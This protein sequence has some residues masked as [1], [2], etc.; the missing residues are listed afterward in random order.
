MY[1]RSL[2]ILIFLTFLFSFQS[3]SKEE[4][5][6]SIHDIKP[7]AY[8]ENGVFKGPMI[9]IVD[10]LLKDL[11]IKGQYQ[12]IPWIRT[13]ESARNGFQ[14]LIVRHSMNED[15]KK[16]LKPILIGFVNREV[17]Y[18]KKRNSSVKVKKFEDL[19]SYRIGVKNSYF[20]SNKF[21]SSSLK[22]THVKNDVQ[23]LQMLK[24][25][26]VD[27]LITYDLEEIKNKAKSVGIN[28]DKEFSL[29]E[30]REEFKNPYFLSIPIKSGLDELY[31]RALCKVLEYR[32][33]GLI[34]KS[35]E[36]FNIKPLLQD[37]SAKASLE[38]ENMCKK[39]VGRIKQDNY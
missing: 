3:L 10:Q 1:S 39:L 19:K 12:L 37:F 29:V 28:F 21:N 35:Y 32:K 5:H 16:F 8:L 30:Y 25:K 27:L 26:R 14:T 7:I 18:I 34:T 2:K 9:K 24:L 23:I 36:D 38:Q 6:I 4:L 31:N 33:S 20:Y 13:L 11:N 17:R 22:K 15:R